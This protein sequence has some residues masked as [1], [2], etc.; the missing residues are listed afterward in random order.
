[1]GELHPSVL[2]TVDLRDRAVALEVDLEPLLAAGGVRQVRPL[3]RFPAVNRDLGVV[4]PEPVLAAELQATISEAGGELLESVRAFDE[5]RGGQ[6]ADGHK[7]V[8]FAL[9]FRSPERT[10]TDAEVDAQVEE[11]RRAL[12]RR[13]GA[14]FRE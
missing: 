5:Y 13:H 1:V 8:A 4:V 6:V 9:T 14:G 11:I 3:P 10:L 2:E 12:R 7:S